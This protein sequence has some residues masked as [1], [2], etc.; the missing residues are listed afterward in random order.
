MAMSQE[1]SRFE[2][3]LVRCGYAQDGPL[4]YVVDGREVVIMRSGVG[5]RKVS[6]L[7][8]KADIL[9]RSTAIIIAGISGAV[10]GLYRI[11]DTIVPQRVS[12]LE[13]RD[14][15]AL[16]DRQTARIKELC[17]LHS[18]PLKPCFQLGTADHL[19]TKQE[20]K[21]VGFVDAV[22]METYHIVKFLKEKKLPDPIVVRTISDHRNQSLPSEK[23]L[24]EFM[25][26]SKQFLLKNALFH[27]LECYRLLTLMHNSKK[28]VTVL[29]QR[30]VLILDFF[31][32]DS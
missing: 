31:D 24:M 6:K 3:E 10:N 7:A 8:G 21:R 1:I 11:G 28:A 14:D 5:G 2:E 22:D 17:A 9:S 29:A 19:V 12:L 27:P 32:K 13:T 15:I 25:R 26:F 16:H 23:S 20:K 18:L 4:R 30:L